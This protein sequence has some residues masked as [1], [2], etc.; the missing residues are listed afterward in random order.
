M[1]DTERLFFWKGSQAL[2]AGQRNVFP[3]SIFIA[4][5]EPQRQVQCDCPFAGNLK[6]DWFLGRIDALIDHVNEKI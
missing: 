5:N 1:S 4:E 3:V 6:P 2:K